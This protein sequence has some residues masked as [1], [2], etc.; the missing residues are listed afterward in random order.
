MYLKRI[1]SIT[2]YCAAE[3]SAPEWPECS[4]RYS[5]VTPVPDGVVSWCKHEQYAATP[6]IPVL[7][8][9]AHQFSIDESVSQ[10]SSEW[11]EPLD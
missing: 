7:C 11:W 1:F 3:R 2:Y 9:T 10:H 4:L 6:L 5:T 8:A